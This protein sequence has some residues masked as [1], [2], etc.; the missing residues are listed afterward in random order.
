V[1]VEL[2]VVQ[3]LTSIAYKHW[4]SPTTLNEERE[5]REEEEDK[6]EED[7]EEEE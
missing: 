7:K 4:C 5:E 1:V 6:E 2:V 3:V